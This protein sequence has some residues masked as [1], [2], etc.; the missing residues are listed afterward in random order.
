VQS[1]VYA[2]LGGLHITA[3]Y[4]DITVTMR[5]QRSTFRRRSTGASRC[6]TIP[7]A[8]CP[9]NSSY[10]G[11]RQIDFVTAQL[12]NIGSLAVSGIDLQADYTTDLPGALAIGDHGAS[13]RLLLA[14][15]K[16]FE[17]STQVQGFVPDDCAGFIGSSCSGQD[18]FA[19]PDIKASL[20]AR[21]SSG[22]LALRAGLRYIGSM[23]IFP[24]T[25]TVVSGASSRTYFDLGGIFHLGEATQISIGIDNVFDEQP[26]VLGAA[27][28]GD[29]N[30][31]TSL[32]DIIGRRYFL[33]LGVRF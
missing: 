16:T 7:S 13:L 28:A 29:A 5:S 21:W 26:P 15:S 19:V 14:V 11:Q 10:G 17:R 32:Y 4:F 6:S 22:P 2:S 23:G 31:D 20:G 30:T 33:S 18:T 8:L 24:G 27:L 25:D 3:D 12:A 9:G 1:S